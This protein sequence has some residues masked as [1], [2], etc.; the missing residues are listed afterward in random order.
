MPKIYLEWDLSKESQKW[1]L[2][3]EVEGHFL[4]LEAQEADTGRTPGLWAGRGG[5]VCGGVRD[6]L[7]GRTGEDRETSSEQRS[8]DCGT[9]G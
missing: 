5:R 8:G 6:R 2:D 1:L 9:V 3:L 4:L 7:R